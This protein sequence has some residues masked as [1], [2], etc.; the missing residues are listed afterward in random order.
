MEESSALAAQK[1]LVLC[2]LRRS[3]KIDASD[4]EHKRPNMSLSKFNMAGLF[5]KDVKKPFLAWKMLDFTT[6]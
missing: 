5:V 6:N 4:N 1:L 2:I 3:I